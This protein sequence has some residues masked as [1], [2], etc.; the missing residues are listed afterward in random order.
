[1]SA[2][3]TTNDFLAKYLSADYPDKKCYVLKNYLNWIQEEASEEYFRQKIKQNTKDEFIIGYFSGS[4]THV[5]DLVSVLP[6][7]EEFMKEHSEVILEIVGYMD[8]PEKYDYLR[9][10]R[11][12]DLFLFKHL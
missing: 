3:I 6:E 1:M 10:E 2:T 8:L 5:K 9:K 7:I 4:P 12:S 11:K